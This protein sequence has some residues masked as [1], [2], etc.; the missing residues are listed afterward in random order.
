MTYI[1]FSSQQPNLFYNFSQKSFPAQAQQPWQ[2]SDSIMLQKKPEENVQKDKNSMKIPLILGTIAL[3]ALGCYMGRGKIKEFLG[4]AE[5]NAK[6]MHEPKP[7]PTPSPAPKPVNPETGAQAATNVPEITDRGAKVLS[8]KFKPADLTASFEKD[9]GKGLKL[10]QKYDKSYKRTFV[11]LKDGKGA[12]RLTRCYAQTGKWVEYR[13]VGKKGQKKFSAE[14]YETTVRK[15]VENG[16]SETIIRN[17]ADKT[18]TR[19]LRNAKNNVLEHVKKDA[20]GNIIDQ[21]KH[22]YSGEK[23]TKTTIMNNFDGKKTTRVINYG[24]KGCGSGEFVDEKGV[25]TFWE[26]TPE[27]YTKKV[28]NGDKTIDIESVFLNPSTKSTTRTVTGKDGKIIDKMTDKITYKSDKC[29][30]PTSEELLNANGQLIARRTYKHASNA[31]DTFAVLRDTET[32]VSENYK[33]LENEID[34]LF[35]RFDGVRVKS[36]YERLNSAK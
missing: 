27:K 18:T 1:S 5:K 25:K 9:Y 23:L 22:E 4:L 13:A 15:F 19:T 31:T 6:N 21:V 34:Y 3:A 16:N 11:E 24:E 2:T 17:F 8:E 26:L 7:N 33:F 28:I 20:N 36:E 35:N 30:I 14:D 12:S 29:I 10:V 32:V